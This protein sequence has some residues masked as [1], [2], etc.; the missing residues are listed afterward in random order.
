MNIIIVGAGNVGS[1]IAGVLSSSHNVL[2]IE[3]DSRK[4]EAVKS[5][6]NVSVLEEDGVNPRVIEEA[7]ARHSADVLIAAMPVDENNLFS[8][9]AAKNAKE[10]IR[11]VAKIRNPDFMRPM[12]EGGYFGTDQIISPELTAANKLTKLAIL[13][14]AVDYDDIEGLGLAVAMFYVADIHTALIGQSAVNVKLPDDCTI[15]AVHR[16]KDVLLCKETTEIQIGDMLCILGSPK[17]IAEFNK[18]IGFA[19]ETKEVIIVGGGIIGSRIASLLEKER[20]YIKI[21]EQ[22]PERCKKLVRELNNVLIIN[23]DGVD[24][25]VLRSENIGRADVVI[26]ATESDEKN[27]LSCLVSRDL[28]ALK[29]ISRYS[30]REYEDVFAVTKIKTIVG[31]HRLIANEVTKTLISDEKAIM[32]MSRDEETLFSVHIRDDSKVKGIP[33]GDL[34]FPDGARAVCIIR[35]EKALFPRLDTIIEKNDHVLLYTYDTKMNRIEKL[36]GIR[37]TDV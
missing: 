11:T 23:A 33:V 8:C 36:F 30:K 37:I 29:V 6:L 25:D 4:S 12:S 3:T 27:L 31:Y 28:G 16:G 10:N 32:R 15:M 14:N 24:P 19:R 9:I 22:N 26:C 18:M 17:A 21:I 7:I 34:Q 5:A 35:D 1:T 2:M 20:K 13:E